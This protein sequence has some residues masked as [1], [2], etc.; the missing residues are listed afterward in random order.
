MTIIS[1]TK[2]KLITNNFFL[3]SK[4]IFLKSEKMINQQFYQKAFFFT[5]LL[6]Y[7]DFLAK[8][9][10]NFLIYILIFSKNLQHKKNDIIFKV[11]KIFSL[12][13]YN[14][15]EK[16]QNNKYYF[17]NY[18]N[19]YERIFKKSNN[20]AITKISFDN[21]LFNIKTNI[22]YI[23]KKSLLDTKIP[24][25]GME[26]IAY[27][28]L[29]NNELKQKNNIFWYN[30]V[31]TISI[32]QNFIKF[33]LNYEFYLTLI[34][35]NLSVAEIIKIKNNYFLFYSILIFRNFFIYKILNLNEKIK[36]TFEFLK[37]LKLKQNIRYYN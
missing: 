34:L 30:L 18:F 8:D 9:F 26:L 32:R 24:S 22:F 6:S 12:L 35:R 29:S 4:E 23:S 1:K 21:N 28:I 3:L 20:Q 5:N 2:K 11:K 17:F 19:F 15:K 7:S 31:N 27:K 33:F 13:G 36:L 37:T 25:F 14:L 16:K 10:Y